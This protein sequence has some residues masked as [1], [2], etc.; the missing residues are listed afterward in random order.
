MSYY[1]MRETVYFALVFCNKEKLDDLKKK[2]PEW[3]NKIVKE[4]DQEMGID[5]MARL[6][7]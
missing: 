3:F 7:N 5:V 2:N 4:L 6:N 1:E